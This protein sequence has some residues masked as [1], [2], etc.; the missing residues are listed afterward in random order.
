MTD[1]LPSS[2]DEEDASS[3][4]INKLETELDDPLQNPRTKS[5]LDY[6]KKLRK[7]N[8]QVGGVSNFIIQ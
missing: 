8:N 2:S 7:I 4:S 5:A 1:L 3:S 6:N